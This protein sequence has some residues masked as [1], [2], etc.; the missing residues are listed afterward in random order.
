M[1]FMELLKDF[2]IKP[3]P[4]TVE[5]PQCNSHVERINQVV[6]NMIKMKELDQFIFNYIDPWSKMLSSVDWAVRTS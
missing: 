4:T 5:N 1:H 3:N 2:D 6:Q